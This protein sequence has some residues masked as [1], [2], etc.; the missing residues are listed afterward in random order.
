MKKYLVLFCMFGA[1]VACNKINEEINQS[2]ANVVYKISINHETGD[3]ATKAVKTGWETNDVVYI[4]FSNISTEKYLKAQ[5]NGASWSFTPM[6]GLTKADYAESGATATAVYFPFDQNNTP[7]YS[8]GW[9]FA[10][11]YYAYY[12]IAEKVG[13]TFTDN[14]MTLALSMSIPE[15]F[16]QFFLVDAG[17]V[18]GTYALLESHLTPQALTGVA[19]D[20]SVVT[21]SKTA[22]YALTG[23]VYGT[24][25][26]KGYLFSGILAA[27]ARNNKADYSISLVEQEPAKGYAINTSVLKKST[28]LYTSATTK[29]ALKLPALA[30]PAWDT[31][32]EPFVDL[33]FGDIMWAT[34]N[35][36]GSG[37]A[38]P[39]ER[40]LFYRWGA[41]TGVEYDKAY[42]CTV[43]D[44]PFS[45][46]YTGA[47]YESLT[48]GG[49]DVVHNFNPAWRMP[50][51]SDFYTLKST[52]NTTLTKD[53][54]M[55]E[56]LFESKKNGLSLFL[57][58]AGYKSGSNAGYATPSNNAN[59]WLSTYVK[60]NGNPHS[61]YIIASSEYIVTSYTRGQYAFV[62][63]PVKPN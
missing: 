20:G 52:S 17:A 46:K 32:N 24:G 57:F 22:G 14:T 53:I 25:A 16:V 3:A 26:E 4:F 21:D 55:K 13:Y 40:G 39:T 51:D 15:G 10:N 62:I 60:G 9:T 5:F 35:F 23:Y 30:K 58:D 18:T 45:T 34:G 1:L 31:L 43:V 47:D 48:E 49:D 50:T 6:G 59:W 63:R 11:T 54:A 7:T 8:G 12:L 41:S 42:D 37:I 56:Y 19:A 28:T 2:D 38:A 44:F 29:R 33:G 61:M 27:D 36:N